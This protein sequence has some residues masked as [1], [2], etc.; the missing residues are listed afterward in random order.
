MARL[1]MALY[2][3][4]ELEPLFA[5]LRLFCKSFFASF[6]T[7]QPSLMWVSLWLLQVYRS[8]LWSSG[9]RS[10]CSSSPYGYPGTY[11][12]AAGLPGLP[13]ELSCMGA[14]SRT[15]NECLVQFNVTLVGEPIGFFTV[16]VADSVRSAVSC[17][18]NTSMLS[19]LPTDVIFVRVLSRGNVSE[20]VTWIQFAPTVSFFCRWHVYDCIL[21]L[22]Y[23]RA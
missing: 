10:A 14:L 16:E 8:S 6:A 4:Q 9:V 20:L 7:S 3:P 22:V 15:G 2:I 21:R 13:F 5:T 23:P 1:R 18:L 11:T 17:A 19:L 12:Y